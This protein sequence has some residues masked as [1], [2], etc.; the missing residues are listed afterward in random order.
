MAVMAGRS[1]AGQS[2]NQKVINK[3][4]TACSFLGKPFL[5]YGIEKS[6]PYFQD[7]LLKSI[8]SFCSNKL[9][10]LIKP[11]KTLSS[12]FVIVQ[13]CQ[14]NPYVKNRYTLK[15]LWSILQRCSIICTTNVAMRL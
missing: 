1:E 7:N 9:R 12:F 13:I 2:G 14:I 3:N 4:I 5:V 15:F 6:S 10:I 8:I 11:P